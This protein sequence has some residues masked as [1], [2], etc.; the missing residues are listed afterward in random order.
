MCVRRV[1]CRILDIAMPPGKPGARIYGGGRNSNLFLSTCISGGSARAM[2]GSHRLSHGCLL[3]LTTP[4]A[5]LAFCASRARSY[6]SQTAC[7][8]SGSGQ[9][10]R[11]C[12]VGGLPVIVI[13][14]RLSELRRGE[15]AWPGN[16]Q[17]PEP[18]EPISG[19]TGIFFKKNREGDSTNGAT[20]PRD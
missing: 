13:P 7:G 9:S 1:P 6:R 20:T 3:L 12:H 14:T 4:D 10:R 17:G 19:E 18:R 5:P 15:R 8:V 2:A 16:R 11:S